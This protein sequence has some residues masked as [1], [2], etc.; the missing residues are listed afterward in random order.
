MKELKFDT[1]VFT[2]SSY[3][4]YNGVS[5]WLF[6]EDGDTVGV[7]IPDN[8]NEVKGAREFRGEAC[9][10]RMLSTVKSSREGKGGKDKV[11]NRIAYCP[12]VGITE[13]NSRQWIELSVQWKLLPRY[14]NL[15]LLKKH[16]VIKF[17]STNKAKIPPSVIYIYLTQLRHLSEA[18]A[19]VNIALYLANE[20]NMNFYAAILLGSQHG[21]GNSNHH[22]VEPWF[23]Y[24][25]KERGIENLRVPIRMVIGLRRLLNE[26]RKYDDRICCKTTT[27]NAF[28]CIKSA[29]GNLPVH[30]VQAKY[31]CNPHVVDAMKAETNEEITNHIQ[32]FE[33]EL[34]NE[35]A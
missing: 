1:S 32:T 27:W 16:F 13:K 30:F 21:C 8:I 29:A 33:Q 12:S 23:S 7:S 26:P 4:R 6:H 5:Y 11:F 22:Y 24:G 20:F 2:R 28:N 14:I 19:L 3:D 34:K 10:S 35:K 15:D 25:E 18:P 31:L 17:G 9:F